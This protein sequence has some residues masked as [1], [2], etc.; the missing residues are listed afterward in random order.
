MAFAFLHTKQLTVRAVNESQSDVHT[1]NSPGGHEYDNVLII[2]MMD[3][4]TSGAGWGPG[5]LAETVALVY[6][7]AYIQDGHPG[8]SGVGGS[9]LGPLNKISSVSFT[10]T[11]TNAAA[12]ATVLILQ[13]A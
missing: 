4:L 5:L 8:N 7:S 9:V 13:V 6:I 12:N 3:G 2:C 10:L 1:W 11:A